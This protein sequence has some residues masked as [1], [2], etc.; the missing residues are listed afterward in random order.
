MPIEYH[1]IKIFHILILFNYGIII[2]SLPDSQF[3]TNL[4]TNQT[5]NNLSFGVIHSLNFYSGQSQPP[6]TSCSW[7]ITNSQLSIRSNYILSIRVIEIENDPTHWSNELSVWTG[8]KEISID[9]INKRSFMIS[10]SSSIQIYFRTRAP[11]LQT[12]NPYIRTSL[13]IRRFLIEFIQ[14]NNDLILNP[15]NNYFQCSTNKILI[16]EQWKCNCLSECLNDDRSD[17]TD[18][19][20]CSMYEPSNSL[21]CQSNEIWCLPSPSKSFNENLID[22]EYDED[23]WMQSHIAYSRKI[24]PK[25]VCVPHNEYQQCSHSTNK[26]ICEKI[27]AWR[28]DHGEI[29]LD[30]YLLNKY[31][32]VCFVIIAKEEYKIKLILNQF[33][34]LQQ[35]SDLELIIYD[36]SEYQ[37][38]II[39]SSNWL[40]KTDTIQTRENHVAT[41]VIRKHSNPIN[42]EQPIDHDVLGYLEMNET[43]K[44]RLRRRDTNLIL[45]NVTWFTSICPDDQILCGGHF[46][47]KCYTKEQRCDGTWD[48]I[49]GDD[50]LG[51]SPESCPTTFACNDRLR[52]PSDQPRCFTWSE[53]CDGNAI[54]TNRTDEKFCTNWWCNSNNGTF[55]CKN[56]NCIYETWVCDGN[57]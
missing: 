14:F 29:L 26:S 31:Q 33:Q 24:D 18:C 39:A 3:S 56:L 25:G 46:E 8:V 57:N 54:C 17:E 50:E 38:R 20:L 16:S 2:N 35:R 9:D 7:I 23:D 30:S 36:G 45:L 21:L 10:S 1:G 28:R 53:R 51:C 11:L 42:D 15:P 43:N 32:S 5:L 4:C 55:L 52:L 27:L 19:P 12:F 6:N 22:T 37:N 41:I 47:T 13:R 40:L 48:C 44:I 34:F 49:S